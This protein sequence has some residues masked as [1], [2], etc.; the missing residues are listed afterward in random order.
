V[1]KNTPFVAGAWARRASMLVA[2]KPRSC[3]SRCAACFF[4]T[5]AGGYAIWLLYGLSVG[6]LPLILVDAAGLLCGSSRSPSR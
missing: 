2:A 6:S 5:Y 1:V 4:A 3:T